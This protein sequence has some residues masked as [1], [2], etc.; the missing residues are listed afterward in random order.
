M[1]MSKQKSIFYIL[2]I[3]SI[4]CALSVGLTWDEDFLIYTQG[5]RTAD[6]LLSLGN[7][8]ENI[9]RGEY[10]SPIY[11]SLK[12]MVINMFP[13]NLRVETSYLINLFFSF[14]VIFGIKKLSEFFFNKDIGKITFLI[15]FFFP[16]FFGHMAFN[17]KDTIIAMSHVWIFYL[18]MDYLRKGNTNNKSSKKIYLASILAAV[19]SGIN[20][21]FLGSLV[22]V[23]LIVLIDIFFLKKIVS[24]RFDKK[25]L[26]THILKG[27][28]IFYFIL[29]LFWIDTHPNIFKLPF[30]FLSDWAF[31]DLFRGYPFMLF[32]G[33]HYIFSELPKSYLFL[34]LLYKTPEFILLT[35]I[36][37][38]IFFFSSNFFTEN[39]DLFN[40]KIS[41]IIL[42]IINPFIIV[43]LTPFS[44][45]DGLRHV[46]WFIPYL[47]IIP[48]LVIY[49]LIKNFSFL[50][51]KII[52][53]VLVT[54]IFYFLYNFL[55]LT[56]YQYTYFNFLAGKKA[57][58]IEKFEND[59]WGSS[60]KE[61]IKKIDFDKNTKF[62]YSV[63]GINRS[64]V[65]IYLKKEGFLNSTMSSPDKSEFIFMTNRAVIKTEGDLYESKNVSNCYLKYKGNNI[66]SV[67]RNDVALS[68]LRKIN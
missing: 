1:K 37:F 14:V 42:M 31:G 45:Y 15:L 32:N 17:S 39:F 59:Y 3:F 22:P 63:C 33:S 65:E 52:S 13:L 61:L 4:Y 29:I 28:L 58:L 34:N 36:L 2:V 18:L 51:V 26:I 41:I 46:L 47:C 48:S 23:F 66:F 20:M 11:Y 30:S 68:I 50:K 5:K 64:I 38:F 8:N 53:G 27:F 49:Y 43:F 62:T 35:Y 56:P 25:I 10:Y 55:I 19:G 44:I 12:Y 16:V 6:Y 57:D 40:Y 7:I 60:T 24:K 9:F 21:F 67:N 54:F